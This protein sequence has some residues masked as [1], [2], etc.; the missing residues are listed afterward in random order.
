[1][2]TKT[3]GSR[4]LQRAAKAASKALATAA[5]REHNRP[6]KD[7][8]A[9]AIQHRV[10]GGWYMARHKNHHA[11]SQEAAEALNELITKHKLTERDQIILWRVHAGTTIAKDGSI[12][13]PKG[14]YA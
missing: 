10:L 4:R 8:L 6:A 11:M 2:K 1:M 3:K 7:A 12:K 5:T 9:E 14:A 13:S